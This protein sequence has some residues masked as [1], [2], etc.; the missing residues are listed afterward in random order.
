MATIE[1]RPML[2]APP[3]YIVPTSVANESPLTRDSGRDDATREA[4]ERIEATLI[5]WGVDQA[6]FDEEELEAPSGATIGRAFA[7]AGRLSRG[8]V[9]APMR[10]VP[11]AHA[12]I[13]FEWRNGNEVRSVHIQRNGND[14][15]RV[16]SAHR[17]VC[18]ERLES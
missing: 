17:L 13:V 14:E 18:R 5:R 7:L 12:G 10:V 11:D 8:G 6:D 4:W 3:N 9:P 15:F 16:M 1:R 2:T